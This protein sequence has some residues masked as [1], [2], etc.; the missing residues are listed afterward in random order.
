MKYLIAPLIILAVAMGYYFGYPPLVKQRNAQVLLNQFSE[1]LSSNHRDKIN[2]FLQQHVSDD[3]VVHLDVAFVALTSQNASKA[4]AQDFD[5]ASFITFIDNIFYTITDTQFQSDITRFILKN[6]STMADVEFAGRG[7]ADGNSYFGGISVMMRF[8]TETTCKAEIRL[9]Q[10]PLQLTKLSC[11][12]PIRSV[13]KPQE[14]SKLQNTDA[15][16]EYLQR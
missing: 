16:K 7:F 12:A 2:Q 4:L 14:A 9:D 13:P 3:A 6:E 5:K 8:S 1:A 11:V 15:L 10:I